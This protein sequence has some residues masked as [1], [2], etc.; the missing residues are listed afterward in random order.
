MPRTSNW[1]RI[2]H[3]Y[4]LK[5][6]TKLNKVALPTAGPSS[7]EAGKSNP[8][9]RRFQD[10]PGYHETWSMR[11]EICTYLDDTIL[12]SYLSHDKPSIR[13]YRWCRRPAAWCSLQASGIA[14]PSQPAATA[15]S[16]PCPFLRQGGRQLQFSA[17]DRGLRCI[18]WLRR[19]KSC[20]LRPGTEERESTEEIG[21]TRG[22]C[23]IV[24][25]RT[26]LP[27]NWS[28]M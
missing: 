1:R 10:E 24:G 28:R 20:G 11:W 8:C 18:G 12:W 5:Q 25:L 4:N 6:A 22:L 21:S 17:D 27:D 13:F 9:M 7:G 14:L 16:D 2:N 19:R 15:Y 23:Y 26:G 3:A